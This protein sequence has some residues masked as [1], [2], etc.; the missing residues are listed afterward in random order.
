MSAERSIREYG[1]WLAACLRRDHLVRE[2]ER[3]RAR[4]RAG[5]RRLVA[6]LRKKPK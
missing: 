6:R 3:R 4:T 1:C 5:L 2:A